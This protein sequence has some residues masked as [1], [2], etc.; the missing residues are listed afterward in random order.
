MEPPRVITTLSTAAEAVDDDLMEALECMLPDS[1]QEESS[2]PVPTVVDMESMMMSLDVQELLPKELGS[3]EVRYLQSAVDT[4]AI[5]AQAQRVRPIKPTDRRFKPFSTAKRRNRRRPKHELE[6]LR[7][8]VVEL[9]EELDALSRKE[10]RALANAPAS[11]AST[12]L[13]ADTSWKEVAEKQKMEVDYSIAENRKLRNRLLGQ[14]QVARVLETAIH[15]QQ[16]QSPQSIPWQLGSAGAP[17]T[18]RAR[19]TDDH[20]F[21]ELNASLDVMYHEID[22]VLTTRGLSNVLHE[23]KGGFHFKREANG[24]SFRHEEARLLPF[25]M[26]LMHHTLWNSLRS[27]ATLR[28]PEVNALNSDHLNLI[29]QDT[30][31][32]TKAHQVKVTKRAAF[33]RYFEDDR[34]IFVWC[35]YVEIAGSSCVRLREKGWSTTSALEF[36][37]GVAAGAASSRNYVQ[38]CITRMAIQVTPEVSSFSEQ[39]AQLRIGD[40]TDLVIG[41]YQRNFGLIHEVVEN[42]LLKDGHSESSSLITS[43]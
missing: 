6:Y 13:P 20:V 11:T 19:M 42:L 34:V 33:R 10:T 15:Q 17:Q 27:G 25:S 32:L 28:C 43:Q 7:G 5:V 35:S 3:V 8:K 21:S 38:G 24:V 22:A 9:Q 29:F 37:R 16:K 39:E 2:T 18:R 26:Q 4:S 23:L 14:L 40:V 12:C 36:H 41:T 31:A 30:L 1:P